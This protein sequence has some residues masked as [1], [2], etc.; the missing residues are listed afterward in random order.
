MCPSSRRVSHPSVHRS[1]PWLSTLHKL[2]LSLSVHVPRHVCR[3]K[4]LPTP[5]TRLHWWRV[6][7]DEA[8]MVESSTAAAAAMARLLPSTHRWCVSSTS[9]CRLGFAVSSNAFQV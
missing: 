2:R 7:V 8:Q 1:S 3:Y 4:V 5:L 9:R 6:C